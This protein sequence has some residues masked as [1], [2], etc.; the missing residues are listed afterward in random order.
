[1]N[2]NDRYVSPS[3]YQK[4]DREYQFFYPADGVGH[5]N[6]KQLLDAWFI[7]ASQKRFPKLILTLS[8]NEMKRFN[9]QRNLPNI[10]NVGKV[11]R[12]KVLEILKDSDAMIFPSSA[13][14]FGIPLLEASAYNIPIL[15]SE[16]DFVRDVCVPDFTFNPLSSTSIADA[17][18]RFMGL[19]RAHNFDI[20]TSSQVRDKILSSCS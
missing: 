14:T 15:A 3:F 11:D 17:V 6:H 20:Y 8:D 7:L 19:E 16:K 9:Y 18:D 1:M 2:Q 5:K 13:E 12:S 4:N 10:C